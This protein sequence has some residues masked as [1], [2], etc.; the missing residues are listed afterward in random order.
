M[1]NGA[2]GRRAG[3]ARMLSLGSTTSAQLFSKSTKYRQMV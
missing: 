1:G 2:S 3:A